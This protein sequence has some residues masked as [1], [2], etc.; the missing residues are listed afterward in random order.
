MEKW[1][2]LIIQLGAGG[3]FALAILAIVFKFLK[4]SRENGMSVT[5]YIKAAITPKL[6]KLQTGH[7]N[8]IEKVAKLPTRDEMEKDLSHL[9]ARIDEHER[10]YHR[11][12]K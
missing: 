11:G 9:H 2:A 10:A 3:I 5:D 1:Q 4:P 12:G 8:I 6:D 7:E